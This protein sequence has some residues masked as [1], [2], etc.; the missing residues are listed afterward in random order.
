MDYEYDIDGVTVKSVNDESIKSQVQNYVYAN[1][2]SFNNKKLIIEESD[3]DY[4]V[5]K[6]SLSEEE[7]IKFSKSL[8]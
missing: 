1:Y 3:S 5:I 7:Q 4:Y 2:S 6:I 8:I